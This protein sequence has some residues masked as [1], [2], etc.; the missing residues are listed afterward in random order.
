MA[1]TTCGSLAGC[2]SY[3]GGPATS[4]SFRFAVT[5]DSRSTGGE[6]ARYRNGV[7]TV[8]LGAIAKDVTEQ[9]VDFLLFPGDMVLGR[10]ND[11][12]LLGAMFDEWQTTMAPV[13]Q[14]G[15][16]IYT[17]RGNHEYNALL[18]GKRNP[19]DPSRKPYLAHFPMPKNGPMGEEGLTYSFSHKNAKIIAFDNYAGRTETFDSTDF[20][21]GSNKGQMMNP[22]VLD[23]VNTSTAGV[24]FVMAHEMLA[25]S[26]SHSDCMANDPYSRDLLVHALGTHHGAYFSGHDHLYLRGVVTNAEGD[27][28]P[29]LVVGTAG[30]PQ[31]DYRPFDA[32]ANGYEGLTRIKGQKVIGSKEDPVFGYLLVTV[33]TDNSW[34]AD[35]RGFRFVKPADP[36]GVALT[37]ITVMDSFRSSDLR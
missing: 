23:Q 28:V 13:Y 37:P 15:I 19:E 14:A 17:T 10:T 34:S 18:K 22:W 33:Y 25:P 20:A 5:D 16:P 29:S 21:R 24:T 30:A 8:V 2:V 12:A 11:T 4:A 9:R 3:S 35:F 6:S 31:Y 7:S 36:Q 32:A 27:T 26:A 1:F